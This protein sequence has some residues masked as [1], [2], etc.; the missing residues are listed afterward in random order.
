MEELSTSSNDP[1]FF[2]HHNFIDFIF[3]NWRQNTLVS[4]VFYPYKLFQT[5]A[6][7]ESVWNSGSPDCYSQAHRADAVMIPFGFVFPA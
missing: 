5:R 4:R 3:E 7:R 1:I 2:L 6:Q